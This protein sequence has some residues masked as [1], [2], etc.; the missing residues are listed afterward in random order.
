M[1][2]QSPLK[3]NDGQVSRFGSGDTVG[4]VH[5]GTGSDLSATGGTGYVVVQ[6][7]SGGVLTSRVLTNSDVP[8][9]IDASKIGDGSVS[10]T[11]FEYLDGV[12]SDVQTQIDG[13]A[14]LVH[15][16]DA[17]AIVSG[18]LP[19]E[20]GGTG[21]DDSFTKGDL[22]VAASSDTLVALPVGGDGAVLIAD[23]GE[24]EGMRWGTLP[25]GSTEQVTVTNSDSV[26]L[27][28][29]MVVRPDPSAGGSVLRAQANSSSTARG[30]GVVLETIAASATGDVQTGNNVSLSTG[31]WDAVTGGSGGLT[32]GAYYYLSTATAGGITSTAPNSTGNMLLRVGL[33]V[34]AT[35]L[36][37]EWAGPYGL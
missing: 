26:S 34:S 21:L 37:L 18:V 5:G 14:D 29:G 2:D 4:V 9:G 30:F 13:K 28:P 33:A 20:H 32:P 8:S 22:L 3:I 7:T 6:E 36:N 24:T 11:E 19:V 27:T 10:N 23:S 31:A 1:A 35:V 15:T 25:A 16:H 12:T 17:D